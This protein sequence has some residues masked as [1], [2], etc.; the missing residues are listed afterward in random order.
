[1]DCETDIVF[2]IVVMFPPFAIEKLT[3]GEVLKIKLSLFTTSKSERMG[4]TL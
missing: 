1:M 3:V 2:T 4:S